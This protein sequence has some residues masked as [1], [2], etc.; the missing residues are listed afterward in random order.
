MERSLIRFSTNNLN[1][2]K[3]VKSDK[4]YH[5]QLGKIDDDFIVIRIIDGIQLFNQELRL[6]CF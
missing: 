1:E 3:D 4:F 5:T 2:Y 6:K